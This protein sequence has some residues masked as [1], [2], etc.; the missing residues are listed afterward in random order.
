MFDLGGYP[1]G[2]THSI[3]YH[4]FLSEAFLSK[5]TFDNTGEKHF[6]GLLVVLYLLSIYLI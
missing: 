3:E 6:M 4:Y 1:L 5:K 2:V